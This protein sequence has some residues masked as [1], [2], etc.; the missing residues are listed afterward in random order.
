MTIDQQVEEIQELLTLNQELTKT[1]KYDPQSY[2]MI[3]LEYQTKILT[4]MMKWD[5]FPFYNNLK[6]QQ[7]R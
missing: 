1:D 2:F 3:G 4:Y 5:E 6:I 7:T